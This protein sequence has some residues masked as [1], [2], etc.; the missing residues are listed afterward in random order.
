MP[1]GVRVFTRYVN[2]QNSKAGY[3]NKIE[4]GKERKFVKIVGRGKKL[5]KVKGK[6]K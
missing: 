2:P 3:R 5:E 6:N 4:E 1:Q